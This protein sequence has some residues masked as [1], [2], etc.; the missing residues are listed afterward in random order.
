[1]RNLKK[2]GLTL[3]FAN[4]AASTQA[5]LITWDG[6]VGGSDW[7]LATNWDT[8]ALPQTGD[9]VVLTENR[10]MDSAFTLTSGKSPL[11]PVNH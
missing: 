11:R 8:D 1:M 5:D 9:S 3:S 2:L 4:L 7:S 6:T 10:Y